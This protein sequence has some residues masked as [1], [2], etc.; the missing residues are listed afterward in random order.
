MLNRYFEEELGQLRELAAEFSRAHP[1]LA[2]MLSGP[3]SDPDV[4]RLLE[5]VAYLTGLVRARLDDEFPEFVQALGNLIFPHYLRPIPS[6]TIVVFE[7]KGQLNEP[8]IVKSGVELASVPVDGIQCIF[9]TCYPVE[10]HPLTLARV[11]MVDMPGSTPAIRLALRLEGF[12]LGN[13]PLH[14]LRF[15]LGDGLPAAAALYLAMFRHLKEIRISAAGAPDYILPR[16]ALIPVGFDRDEA[17]IPYPG[18]AYP[19]YR[20]LQEYFVL[21]E[22][23]LFA[24]LTGLQGWRERGPGQEFTIEFRLDTRPA[25][26]PPVGSNSLLLNAAPAV[27]LFAIDAEPILLDHKREEYRIVPSNRIRAGSCIFSVDEVLGHRAGAA[28]SRVYRRFGLFGEDDTD[29]TYEVIMRPAEHRGL[30]AYLSVA[31][32]PGVAPEPETLTLR[33]TCTNGSLPDGLHPGDIC[34]PTDT[35]PE[36]LSFRNIRRPTQ[37]IL[38]LEG[39][40]MLGRLLSHIAL[41]YA[42]IGDA[43]NLRGLLSLYAF[44]SGMEHA[45]DNANRRRIEGIAELAITPTSRIVG[46]I[47]MRGQRIELRCRGD[48]FAG[49]GDLFLF[50]TIFDRFM[51]DYATLNTFTR[52]EMEVAATG[53]RYSWP[54][55][56]GRQPLI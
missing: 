5:G 41:N 37:S 13:W 38:P 1:A 11:E 50:G 12:A 32:P 35:S 55:R 40:R 39:S 29:A 51:A 24:D 8:A 56:V 36:R 30:D 21:P 10:V 9:R 53:E 46:G 19:G 45:R 28:P 48:H 43:A 7:P 22:K 42:S 17:L 31:Y 54:E 49:P 44:A 47:M 2:P 33:L 6:C 26:M 16:E 18:N 15:H 20:V 25:W 4:E 23:F 34:R 14:R 3:S 27:N 52:T